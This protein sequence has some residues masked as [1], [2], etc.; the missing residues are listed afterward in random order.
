MTRVSHFTMLGPSKATIT[1]ESIGGINWCHPIIVEN[2]V[3]FAKETLRGTNWKF[4]ASVDIN[5]QNLL[6]QAR[7]VRSGR[8]LIAEKRIVIDE[9]SFVSLNAE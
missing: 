1:K 9:N 7:S 3:R 5:S 8:Q 4:D 2:E 6:F